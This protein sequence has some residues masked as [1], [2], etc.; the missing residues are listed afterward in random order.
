MTTECILLILD[1]LVIHTL[2]IDKI[3]WRCRMSR[4]HRVT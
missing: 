4:C 1:F 2:D 3:P